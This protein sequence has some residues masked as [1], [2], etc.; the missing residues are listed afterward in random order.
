MGF[1]STITQKAKAILG[2]IWPKWE[3]KSTRFCVIVLLG[4][5]HL[6]LL[7]RGACRHANIYFRDF[8]HVLEKLRY[9]SVVLVCQTQTFDSALILQPH[10]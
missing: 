10:R 5:M 9:F 2:T 1:R 7:C 8:R 4:A 3:G 6:G